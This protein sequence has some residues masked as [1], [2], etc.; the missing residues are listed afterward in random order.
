[1]APQIVNAGY[2][3]VPP[4]IFP[5]GIPAAFFLRRRR[6]GQLR[7]HRH[8]YRHEMSHGFITSAVRQGRQH[9]R[10][11][12]PAHSRSSSGRPLLVE[13]YGAYDRD[14]VHVT[15]SSAGENIADYAG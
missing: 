5:A 1:M 10:R 14:G 4:K 12:T 9:A 11:W 15:A 7:R 13:Q 8:G 2:N 6:H 3:P